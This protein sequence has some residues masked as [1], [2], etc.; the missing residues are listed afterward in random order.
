MGVE[1]QINGL[2]DRKIRN[3]GDSYKKACEFGNER[4]NGVSIRKG[5]LLITE[6]LIIFI[7][8]KILGVFGGRS[9][10]Q[11]TRKSGNLSDF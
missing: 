5:Y 10:G 2:I 1:R 9:K 8:K 7:E 6:V 3:L 4:Q 11:Y